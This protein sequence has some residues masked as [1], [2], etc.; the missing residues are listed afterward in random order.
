MNELV[1]WV[2]DNIISFVAIV[3]AGFAFLRKEKKDMDTKIDDKINK[4]LD[5]GDFSYF[6]EEQARQC[7]SCRTQQLAANRRMGEELD[8]YKDR[9][10]EG[11]KRFTRIEKCLIFLVEKQEEGAA[12]KIGLYQ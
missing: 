8:E 10:S 9:I 1:E 11:D 6:K 7:Q 12:A 3:T 2:K 4:K 5:V